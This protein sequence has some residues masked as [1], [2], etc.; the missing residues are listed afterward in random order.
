MGSAVRT[1]IV[2]VPTP[3]SLAFA[4][5][6]W[7]AQALAVRSDGPLEPCLATTALVVSQINLQ[8][9]KQ[10]IKTHERRFFQD[11]HPSVY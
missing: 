9:L 4:S 10:N 5:T 11:H 3:R 2:R 7:M 6:L 8:Q 1:V